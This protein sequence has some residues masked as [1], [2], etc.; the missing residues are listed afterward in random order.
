MNL[1]SIDDGSFYPD[2]AM[3]VEGRRWGAV[4]WKKL[5]VQAVS[6]SVI[7]GLEM[8]IEGYYVFK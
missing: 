3:T 5:S 2:L 1:T 8:S 4:S 6:L 7:K